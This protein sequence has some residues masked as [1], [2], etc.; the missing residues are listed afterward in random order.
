LSRPG[1]ENP[2]EAEIAWAAGL[3]EGEGSITWPRGEW[4]VRLQ[5]K[6]TDQDVADRLLTIL[7][8]RVNGPYQYNVEGRPARKPFWVWMVNGPMV[9]DVARLLEPWMCKRRRARMEEVGL[10]DSTP[11][12]D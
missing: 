3:F 11:E 6:T 7:G 12:G 5:V 2:S 10:F 8:G 1:L 4:D 9:Y